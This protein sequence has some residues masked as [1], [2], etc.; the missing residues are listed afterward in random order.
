MCGR[1]WAGRA[2]HSAEVGELCLTRSFASRIP[3]ERRTNCKGGW[4]GCGTTESGEGL[5][6]LGLIQRN[7]RTGLQGLRRCHR[8]LRPSQGALTRG[9]IALLLDLSLA[10]NLSVLV[11]EA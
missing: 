7:E 10:E 8:L 5:G 2:R 1:L 3:P 11:H 4:R 6:R 9:R